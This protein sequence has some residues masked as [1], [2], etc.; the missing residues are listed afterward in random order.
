MAADLTPIAVAAEDAGFAKL[1]VMDHVWQIRRSGPPSTTC[2]RRTRRWVPR[3][4]HRAH[5]AAGVGHRGRLPRA[6]PARQVRHHARRALR[7]PGLARHR[8][9]VERGGVARARPAVPAHR[10]AVRAARRGA[11]DL[12]ADVQRRRRRRTRASTTTSAA[13]STAAAAAAPAPAD[14]DRR[15]RARRRRCGW[16][17]STPTPATCSPSPDIEHKL[18]VLRGHCADVGRDYDEIEK[19]VM[20]P[21]DVGRD[22]ANVDAILA[23]LSELAAARH[24]PR[25][26]PVDGCRD[27]HPD[28]H[29]G[30]AGHPGRGCALTYFR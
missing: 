16:S 25:A 2:S 27:D 19:T 1:S 13:R 15:R 9:G 4:A 24:R 23:R 14:P 5:R 17:R 29:H 3:R 8:R 6:R 22:G 10:R 7:R 28:R 26:R 30:R 20:M 21:L 18:D 11:A 12:P